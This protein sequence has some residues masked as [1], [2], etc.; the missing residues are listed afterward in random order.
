MPFNSLTD[1]FFSKKHRV[2]FRDVSFIIH[3]TR[4]VPLAFSTEIPHACSPSHK[5]Q[6]HACH[7][8]K[9]SLP[10][11]SASDAEE[12]I[13]LRHKYFMSGHH[14]TGT[15]YNNKIQRVEHISHNQS[16]PWTSV[17]NK[18]ISLNILGQIYCHHSP[19]Y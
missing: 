14:M 7:H 15:K 2:I 19:T 6:C 3:Y 1:F 16:C 10:P 18:M 12:H 5:F 11:L 17:T 8:I 9:Y 4:C 13:S